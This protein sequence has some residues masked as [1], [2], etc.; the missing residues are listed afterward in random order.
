[1]CHEQVCCAASKANRVLGLMKSTFSYW[2]DDIARIIYPTFIR[3]NLEFASS[4]WNS[5]LKYDSNKLKSVQ[6]RG[7]LTTESYHLPYQEELER[8]DLTHL[9]CMRERADFIYTDLQNRSRP[10]ES[11][12][13]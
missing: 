11:K 5:D 2:S 1:M 7:T 13:K 10:R 3:Q 9:S 6:R 12:L 8:L 4:V